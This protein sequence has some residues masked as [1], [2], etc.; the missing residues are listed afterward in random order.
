[1]QNASLLGEEYDRLMEIKVQH[2]RMGEKY[3][4]RVTRRASLDTDRVNISE[5][6]TRTGIWMQLRNNKPEMEESNRSEAMGLLFFFLS[7]AILSLAPDFHLFL[8]KQST[9]P[10][11]EGIMGL[12][13]Y[14]IS[15]D[16]IGAEQDVYE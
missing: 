2:E 3:G 12:A 9:E 6:M 8:C 16:F 15:D 4:Q 10:R 13:R 11:K 14:K 1:M 5:E 7:P